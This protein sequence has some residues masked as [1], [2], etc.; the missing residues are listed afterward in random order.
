MIKKYMNLIIGGTLIFLFVIWTLLVKF[1]DVTNN[2]LGGTLIG[3]TSMNEYFN[4]LIGV[5]LT[6]YKVTDYLMYFTL[7]IAFMFACIA[8]YQLITR[9]SFKKIDF[10]LYILFA[11][12]ALV[13]ILFIFFEKVIINYRPVMVE[14][15]VEASYPSTHMLVCI[16]ILLSA[17]FMSNYLL[18][19]FKVIK[20]VVITFLFVLLVLNVVGRTLSGVHWISDIIGGCL[21]SIGLYLIFVHLNETIRLKLNK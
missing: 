6:L 12:Y 5:N 17:A 3:L 10:Q 7:F 11:F 18:K 9:K 8:I 1:V 13:V 20:N 19:D 4:D 16:F 14:G 2:G 21:L 15:K